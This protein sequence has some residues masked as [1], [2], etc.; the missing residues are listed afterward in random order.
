MLAQA[1]SFRGQ[2]QRPFGF[3]IFAGGEAITIFKARLRKRILRRTKLFT[4][5]KTQ[6]H[7]VYRTPSLRGLKVAA[8]Q[9]KLGLPKR[10]GLPLL[11]SYVRSR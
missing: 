7:S 3:L 5:E 9:R 4:A 2:R 1:H 10:C 11:Q 6:P 8:W